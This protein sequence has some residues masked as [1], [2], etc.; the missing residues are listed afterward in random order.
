MVKSHLFEGELMFRIDRI[1]PEF[2]AH[3]LHENDRVEFDV[4]A[5]E[6]GKAVAVAVKPVLDRKPYDVLGQRQRGYVRRVAEGWGFLNAAAFDGDLCVHRDN[7]LL[8]PGSE[9]GSD[10][11]PILRTGQVVE[12][13]VAVDD[14]GRAVAKQLTARALLRP[15]DWIGHRLRGYIRSFNGHRA[16]GFINSDIFAGDLFVHRH[17]L[18]AQC[19]NA[20]LGRSTVVEF[21]I[22]R[23]SHPKGA[24]NRVVARNVAVLGPPE[25]AA[26]LLPAPALQSAAAHAAMSET[27]Q[28]AAEPAALQAPSESGTG[29]EVAGESTG[30]QEP[31]PLIWAPTPDAVVVGEFLTLLCSQD[32]ARLRQ[33]TE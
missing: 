6:S 17:S 3:P 18:L 32:L 24:K 1:M 33:A 20:Q 10:G 9:A 29:S 7:L 13:D 23:D 14:R 2:Q 22:A 21:D 16:F 28:P 19:Q 8:E 31:P 11:Q 30:P 27:T 26:V 15:C 25:A 4:Q 12:F 5:D